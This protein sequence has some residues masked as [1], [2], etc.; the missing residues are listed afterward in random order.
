MSTTHGSPADRPF[1]DELSLTVAQPPASAVLA[2]TSAR[3]APTVISFLRMRTSF[4]RVL[5]IHRSAAGGSVACIVD[6]WLRDRGR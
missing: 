2:D 4:S 5:D 1:G 3:A 6:E